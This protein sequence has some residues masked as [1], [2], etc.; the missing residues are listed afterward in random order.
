MVICKKPKSFV[1]NYKL[2]ALL[3]FQGFDTNGTSN[4]GMIKRNFKYMFKTSLMILYKTF[5]QVCPITLRVLCPNLEPSILQR[6]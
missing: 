1:N 4:L 3:K 6:H 5:S 2:R